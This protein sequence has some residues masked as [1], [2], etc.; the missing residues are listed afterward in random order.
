MLL[1]PFINHRKSGSLFGFSEAT[2][3]DLAS[4]LLFFFPSLSFIVV[5]SITVVPIFSRCP[6]LCSP[7]PCSHGQS[8]HGCPQVIHTWSLATPFPFFPPFPLPPLA[9]VCLFHVSTSLVLFF[10]LVYFVHQIPV[11]SEIIC[12]LS[13]TDWLISLN[14]IVS[15]SNPCCH[16]R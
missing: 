9:A 7:F 1:L 3:R 12:Y 15:S 5:Y 10:L 13:F 11:I 14:I 4:W 8:P 16:K 2:I 6:P